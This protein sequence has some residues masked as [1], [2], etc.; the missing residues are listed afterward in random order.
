MGHCLLLA[1][2]TTHRRADWADS[3]E[4]PI[5][6][7]LNQPA[8]TNHP[9]LLST[10]FYSSP[11]GPPPSKPCH[12]FHNP[13][14]YLVP[15]MTPKFSSLAKLILASLVLAPL[16]S[17]T[18][19]AEKRD[20]FTPKWPYGKEMV[21]ASPPPPRLPSLTPF[22]RPPFPLASNYY[23]RLSATEWVD[24]IGP[25]RQPRWLAC[26]RA[27]DHAVPVQESR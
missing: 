14:P 21:S 17:A 22:L 4:R 23:H 18:E 9:F 26:R 24:G 7:A 20:S 3:S 19:V 13:N 10:S 2:R 11:T 5:N 27:V 12:S 16:C 15:M 6:S 1:N 25:W 8:K